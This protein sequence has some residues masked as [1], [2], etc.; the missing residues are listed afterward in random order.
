MYTAIKN[1]CENSEDNG[2][3]LINTP[4]G[5]GKTY[6]VLEYICEASLN[7]NNKDKKYIFITN[8][9]KN[10]PREDLE[11]H[12]LKEREGYSSK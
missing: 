10:L 6:D 12:F 7:P 1:F 4:T 2:L 3:F 9:K 8:L 11:K 5:S